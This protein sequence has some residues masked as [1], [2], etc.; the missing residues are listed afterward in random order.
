[1][2]KV[3]HTARKRLYVAASLCEMPPT[4]EETE[5]RRHRCVS[6][7]WLGVESMNKKQTKKQLEERVIELEKKIAELQSQ[8]VELALRTPV[9]INPVVN[10]PITVPVPQPTWPPYMPYY[11]GDPPPGTYPTITCNGGQVGILE[12]AQA[13]INS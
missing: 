4:S 13:L 2:V 12:K 5:A 11:I 1:M 10:P 3:G 7:V 9:V 8:I 6:Q